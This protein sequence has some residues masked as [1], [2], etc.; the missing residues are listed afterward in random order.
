MAD[1]QNSGRR[2]ASQEKAY[3]TLKEMIIVQ[4][5]KPNELVSEKSLSELTG[6]GRAS[7]RT[8]LQNLRN[9]GLVEIYAQRGCRIAGIDVVVQMKVLEVRAELER[10]MAIRAARNIAPDA[11]TKLTDSAQRLLLAARDRDDAQFMAALKD[12]HDQMAAAS[13]NEIL[14][15]SVNQ[16]QGLSRRF[17]YAH[18]ARFADMLRAAELHAAR[19]AAICAHDC[20]A[21]ANASD[22]LVEYLAQFTNRV[23]SN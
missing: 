12:V 4:D 15:R 17:W 3:E 22:R 2:G 10:L 7:I 8:A 21:A 11:A 19:V 16:I 13:D 20:D 23:V 14:A 5:L 18:H 1:A 6:L 9:D